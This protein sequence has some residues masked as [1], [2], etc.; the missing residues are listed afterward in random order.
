MPLDVSSPS[1]LPETSRLTTRCQFCASMAASCSILC[2][3]GDSLSQKRL[4]IWTGLVAYTWLV[5][6]TYF[7]TSYIL[8]DRITEYGFSCPSTALLS[9]ALY[10]S[11]K[12]IG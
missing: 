7:C 4:L 3:A 11:A 12:G 6:L 5:A 8:F 1:A 9:S 2:S 10:S